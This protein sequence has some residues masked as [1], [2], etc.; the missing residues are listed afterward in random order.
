MRIK[1]GLQSLCFISLAALTMSCGM[2]QRHGASGYY[3]E[4]QYASD[5][6]LES[7]AYRNYRG[8]MGGGRNPN[9][10][11]LD[12]LE[13]R[14]QTE[15]EA[16]QYNNVKQNLNE[17]ARVQYLKQKDQNSRGRYLA[18]VGVTDFN[19]FDSGVNAAIEESDLVLGMPRDAVMKSWGEPEAIEVAGNP[20]YGNERWIYTHF[21][22]STEGFQK[23][24][25]LV[26]FERGRVVGWET[27]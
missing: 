16:N 14:I 22:S 26:Y 21:E 6:S 2:L 13:R 4:D 1:N 9:R 20:N 5:Q 7:G 18:S 17:K 24:E 25:R 12:S 23:Q 10:S 8:Q 27:R 19:T 15:D 11:E 3:T